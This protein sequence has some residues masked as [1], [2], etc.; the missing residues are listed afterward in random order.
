MSYG[1]NETEPN[2]R[3]DPPG[4]SRPPLV[5][6]QEA[7]SRRKYRLAAT[8]LDHLAEWAPLEECREAVRAAAHAMKDI[9]NKFS[10]PGNPREPG[11]DTLR[12]IAAGTWLRWAVLVRS[13]LE[14]KRLG[15]KSLEAVIDHSQA[16]LAVDL[17]TPER[18]LRELRAKRWLSD[19]A[20]ADILRQ[21]QILEAGPALGDPRPSVIPHGHRQDDLSRVPL[22]G[23]RRTYRARFAK[24]YAVSEHSLRNAMPDIKE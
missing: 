9:G 6:L 5:E 18:E 23:F 12:S 10:G 20:A 1:L 14:G 13:F 19:P 4:Q 7:L 2:A 17:A 3:D 24:H 22:Q 8:W 15:P 21:A 11:M 16:D